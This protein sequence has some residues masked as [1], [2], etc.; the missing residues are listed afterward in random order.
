M[1][2]AETQ[3]RRDRQQ[4]WRR[5]LFFFLGVSAPLRDYLFQTSRSATLPQICDAR[6]P[7]VPPSC[8][9]PATVG[10]G[11]QCEGPELTDTA[12][13]F[14]RWGQRER[15]GTALCRI[16]NRFSSEVP[17]TCPSPAAAGE[18]TR[19]ERPELTDIA[20]QFGSE[21]S[22]GVEARGRGARNARSDYPLSPIPYPLLLQNS[23]RTPIV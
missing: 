9:S 8:L 7:D 23:A 17:P 3:R 1:F 4:D 15:H 13:L 20:H 10:E 12:H 22:L 16:A 6:A 14:G 19:S 5:S 18:G 21:A 11:T 2:L